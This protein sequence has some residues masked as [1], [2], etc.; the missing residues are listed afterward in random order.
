MPDAREQLD[1]RCINTIRM[2]AA[3]AVQKAKSGHPGMP[4]GMADVGAVLAVQPAL[5]VC[6]V[7]V[8][9]PGNTG[10]IIRAADAAGATGVAAVASDPH[11]PFTVLVLGGEHR[12]RAMIAREKGLEPLAD[13]LWTQDPAT[14][15]SG[16]AAPF[17]NQPSNTNGL[18]AQMVEVAG[19]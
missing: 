16:A 8:Q 7:H 19:C 5:I 14:D 6:A 3:D 10:A 18:V 1:Q 11:R 9:D 15:P 4:M 12:T 13:L 17:V 2:L